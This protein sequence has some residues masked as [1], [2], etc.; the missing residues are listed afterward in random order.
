VDKDGDFVLIAND[1]RRFSRTGI[2]VQAGASI[3]R[4]INQFQTRDMDQDGLDD[5]VYITQA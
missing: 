5:I 2:A 1:N 3:P 4:S